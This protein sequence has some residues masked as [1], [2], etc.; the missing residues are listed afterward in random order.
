MTKSSAQ[1][2]SVKSQIGLF[3]AIILGLGSI[4][5]TGVFV[6]LAIAT[7]ISG[8]GIFIAIGLGATIAL[9]NGLS[10]AQLATAHPVSG[11]TYAY[12]YRYLNPW[13][14]F[15]AGWLFLL[16]KSA[17]AATAALG[18]SSYLLEA[19]NA[20][21]HYRI[22]IA[23]AAVGFM[24]TIAACGIKKSNWLNSAIVG[25]TL[26]TLGSFV[27]VGLGQPDTL[28]SPTLT[29]PTTNSFTVPNVLQATALMFVAYTGYGRI[30]TM[31]EEVENPRR[32][33]PI[34]VFVTLGITMLL[35]L[36]IAGVAA[37]TIGLD[38]FGLMIGESLPPLQAAAQHLQPPLPIAMIVGIGAITAMLGV[39]L[40]L[41][42]GLSRVMMAMGRNGD[43]PR[44]TARLNAA[45]TTPTIAIW[46]MGAIVASL[47]AIGNVK[48][49]W[50]F[51]AFNVLAYY[52]L[53]NLCALRLPAGDRFYPRWI[54]IVGLVSCATLAFWVDAQVWQIGLGII[55]V[56]CLWR[57]ILRAVSR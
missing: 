35:Y 2:P 24:T 57:L 34:A 54:A 41:L 18:F 10:A 21:T 20:P 43:M 16:A 1:S 7:E 32:S 3:G 29:A 36:A 45:R 39:L 55:G 13:L 42:L 23:L 49:T 26:L 33:I 56:G 46:V 52:S 47:V 11:G 38:G 25:I 15:I 37:Q 31:T 8:Q 40:N 44:Q 6:S 9:C 50:S 19:L 28:L 22:P 4:L 30:T 5:G 48:T 27:L 17:S 51:S 12:G 53:A 14:G